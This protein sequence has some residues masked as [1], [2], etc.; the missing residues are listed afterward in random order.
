LLVHKNERLHYNRKYLNNKLTQVWKW[1]IWF[2]TSGHCW[3]RSSPS[4]HNSHYTMLLR[5]HHH[6]H[7]NHWEIKSELQDHSK[8]PMRLDLER[9]HK[10]L[11]YHMR[12][13]NKTILISSPSTINVFVKQMLLKY[14]P[15]KRELP[16]YCF[17]FLCSKRH[18]IMQYYNSILKPSK[19]QV[20]CGNKGNGLHVPF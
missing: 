1:A 9:G 10:I 5:M 8:V 2:S 13:C 19:S 12:H 20:Q 17:S 7:L 15:W 14:D 6:H 16:L 11:W 18:N 4:C 3:R